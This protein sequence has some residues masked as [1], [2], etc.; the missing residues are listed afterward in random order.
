MVGGEAQLGAG[1]QGVSHDRILSFYSRLA[2]RA[3]DVDEAVFSSELATAD[4]NMAI[5]YMLRNVGILD[6]DDNAVIR[7]VR[8]KGYALAAE[9]DA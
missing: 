1:L 9:D 3:L 5:A 7:T 2:G 6:D 8:G 4:R